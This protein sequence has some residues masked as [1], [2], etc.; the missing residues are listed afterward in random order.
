M[1]NYGL[2]IRSE[3]FAD[4]SANDILHMIKELPDA[5][6][7]FKVLTDPFGTVKDM[8]FL[9]ANEKYA[10]L[11]GKSS[12]ELVGATF[13]TAVTNRDEDWIRLSYQAAFM[14]QSVINRTYNTAFCKWF[15]FWAVPVYKKGYCAFII[16]DVTAEKR[17]E[18]TREIITN[19]N[20]VII[21]CAKVLSA[22]DFKKGIKAALKIIGTVLKADRAFVV[23]NHDGAVGEIYEWMDRNSGMGL[24]SKK[25]FEKYDLFT[26]W[27]KCFSDDN[28]LIVEDS[29]DILAKN[30]DVFESVLSGRIT[31]YAIAKLKDKADTIGYLVVD[32]FCLNCEVNLREVM[33]SVAIFFS[34]E[35]R[36]Y[37]L[38]NEMMY[39]SS[40]DVLTQLGNRNAFNETLTMID[41]MN[42][43]VGVCFVDINGLKEV[44][45]SKGHDA[46]DDLIR[47]VGAAVSAVFK[48]K[49]CYRIGGDEFVA[50]VPQVESD[51]FGELIEKLRKK[52]KK[53]PMAIGA[54]WNDTA[55]NIEMLVSAADKLMYNDKAN[56]YSNTPNN[57][58]HQ[59]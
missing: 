51:Y 21:E 59:E 33:E 40:H 48:K 43:P 49:Y 34:E 8:Q 9:F 37:S 23:E 17:K 26:M 10:S 22:S 29:K 15:E 55:E 11:V 28:V 44:N 27:D 39:L 42:V 30:K 56:Y 47:E 19:S 1:E 35:I 24:P 6:C 2:G 45:D 25:D 53:I 16:H 32:N 36:N 18:E 54:V 20:N 7:I 5:C 12:A 31:C 14:R 52:S 38:G 58:R 3:E 50:V 41:G 46:G 57:R 4:F 13:Y